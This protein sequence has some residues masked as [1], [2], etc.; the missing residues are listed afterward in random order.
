ML[1]DLLFLDLALGDPLKAAD[2]TSGLARARPG[3]RYRRGALEAKQARGRE[4]AAETLGLRA[5]AFK[6][7]GAGRGFA[8]RGRA[9]SRSEHHRV[10]A[11]ERNPLFLGVDA[12]IRQAAIDARAHRAIF[13]CAA[14]GAERGAIA[15][16]QR[17]KGDALSMRGPIA[18]AQRATSVGQERLAERHGAG[19]IL[20]AH[21]IHGEGK[22]ACRQ[23]ARHAANGEPA[24]QARHRP[25]RWRRRAA[26]ELGADG[27][28][29]IKEKRIT[30]VA[31]PVR[32]IDGLYFAEAE[33]RAHAG[34][35]QH[36][37][38]CW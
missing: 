12:A 10:L 35:E 13:I 17:F 5:R 15:G 16:R 9:G 14:I 23:R 31:A 4:I 18:E 3:L 2:E 11:R 7:R 22:E 33:R 8:R 28:D 26:F 25:A 32:K 37:K 27:G 6:R 36:R 24:H 30:R 34:F 29:Q 38:L 21:E 1:D 20:H 19:V